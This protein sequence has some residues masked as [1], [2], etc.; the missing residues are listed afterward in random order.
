[1]PVITKMLR[2]F[3]VDKLLIKFTNKLKVRFFSQVNNIN[4]INRADI[5]VS[6]LN[7][8]ERYKT[9]AKMASNFPLAYLYHLPRHILGH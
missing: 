9:T 2:F 6:F 1:M 8:N 7:P 4:H 5:A 3:D